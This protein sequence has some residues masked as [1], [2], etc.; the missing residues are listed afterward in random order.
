MSPYGEIMTTDMFHPR[1]ALICA[2][3]NLRRA[4]RLFQQGSSTSAILA[5]YDAVLFGM[6]Y[7]IARH[8]DCVNA[9]L[10]DAIELFQT[11]AHAGVFEDQH[12][13]N[14]LS[15]MVERALWQGAASFD[16]NA[17]VIEVEEMLVKLEIL[18]GKNPDGSENQKITPT[19]KEGDAY[20]QT[21]GI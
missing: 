2:R 12:A 14:R 15:L 8:E 3:L 16:G 5:L 20:L 21:T 1:V 9:D 11:L 17:I 4:K 13:F 18:S 6:H 7:Y 19:W 10:G